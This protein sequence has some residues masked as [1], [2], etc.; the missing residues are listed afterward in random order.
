M[1][2]RQAPAAVLPLS[3]SPPA[4]PPLSVR[5]LRLGYG[6]NPVLHDLDLDI[7]EGQ[8]TVIVGPN[9]CGKSTLLKALARLLPPTA[10]EV[11]LEGQPLLGLP[12]RHVAQRLALLQQAPSLPEGVSVHDLVAQGRF[13]HQGWL[14]RPHPGDQAAI[15]RALAQTGLAALANRPVAALSGGQRQRAWIAMVLAQDTP[16]ILLD[17]PTAWLDLRVQLDLMACLH[18][19]SRA[20]GRTLVLVLHELNLAAAYADHM[21]MLRDG[22]LIAQGTAE[23]VMTPALLRQVFGLEA[24]VIADPI[25]GRPVCLPVC[26]PV[27]TA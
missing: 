15:D 25:T 22:R 5:G 20:A 3:L 9:G 1:L 6:A 2:D 17:E 18:R 21:V 14:G 10:G 12:T 23:A 11:R 19:L 7:P 26:Q 13:P 16:L 8:M 4:T 24:S 27:A